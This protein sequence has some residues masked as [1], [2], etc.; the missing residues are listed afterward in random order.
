MDMLFKIMLFLHLTSLAVGTTATVAMPL[1]GRQLAT[2]SPQAKPALG[3]IAGRI[4]AYSRGAFGI[5]VV[6]GIAM[7]YLRYGGDATAL[8]PWFAVKLALA[9]V[10]FAVMVITSVA[11]GRVKPQV[12]GMISR[13]ALLGVIASAVMA[14]N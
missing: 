2:G 9:V 1:L 8:G 5:L 3:A 11:P 4:Q 10:V 13:F 7:L 6:S 12:M 14:F